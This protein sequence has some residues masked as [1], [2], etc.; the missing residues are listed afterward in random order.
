MPENISWVAE[1]SSKLSLKILGNG[2]LSDCRNES[3][4]SRGV[5]RPQT[6]IANVTG[7]DVQ[8]V[9]NS[10]WQVVE[11]LVSTVIGRDKGVV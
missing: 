5:K 7:A 6:H 9:R 8:T 10:L 3:L 1:L 4:R 11:N 2:E